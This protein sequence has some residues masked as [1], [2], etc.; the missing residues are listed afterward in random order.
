MAGRLFTVLYRPFR[1]MLTIQYLEDSPELA[2][3]PVDAAVERLRRAADRIPFSHLL[4][5]W[6]LP[7][8]LLEACRAEAQRLGIRFLR[9][10]P[11]LA[12]DAV[13]EAAARS[14][15]IGLAR[16]PVSRFR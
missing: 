1:C 7:A 15:V 3:L 9:W 4:I 8:P 14:Q 10:H 16:V 5:G 11:V 6:N 12:G 2:R 13:L